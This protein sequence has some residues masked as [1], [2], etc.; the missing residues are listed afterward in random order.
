MPILPPSS[1]AP[2]P[3]VEDV[4]KR[5]RVIINDAA[6]SI[7]GNLLSDAQ[8]YSV[9]YVNEAYEALQDELV[10]RGVE[11]YTQETIL[12]FVDPVNP[13]DPATQIHIDFREF[14]DGTSFFNAPLLP[15]DL[16]IP[17]RLW[18][19][20]TGT[21]QT[22]I[23]MLPV[24]DGLPTIPQ[25]AR[26]RWWEWRNDTL[27]MIGALQLNDIRMRYLSYLP[28]LVGPTDPVKI[29]RSVNAMAFLTAAAFAAARGSPLA[30]SFRSQADVFISNIASRTARRKQRGSH[31]RQPYGGTGMI[32]GTG[33]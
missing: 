31:R 17:I 15:Q 4:L 18:E 29:F 8:P 10:S 2:Y 3:T 19:R 27:Y 30:D 11:T 26:L 23:P 7:G 21:L 33:W 24:N 20:Q 5:A 14:F 28:K 1:V 13:I 16:I 12:G 32:R 6:Q 9:E 25:T 22:F